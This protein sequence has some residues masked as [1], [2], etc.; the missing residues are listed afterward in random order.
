MSVRTLL[1]SSIKSRSAVRMGAMGEGEHNIKECAE[2]EHL[3]RRGI[4]KC[5]FG[6]RERTLCEKAV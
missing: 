3:E 6:E 4:A 1:G 2:R 5:I